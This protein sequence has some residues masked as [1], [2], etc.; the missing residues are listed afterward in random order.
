MVILTNCDKD[1]PKL[2]GDVTLT[3]YSSSTASIFVETEIL[4]DKSDT[5]PL[6]DLGRQQLINN[7]NAVYEVQG[8]NYGNYYARYTRLDQ[9]G[10]AVGVPRLKPFQARA[11][12]HTEVLIRL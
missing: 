6:I 11:N 3:F 4:I 12:E 5:E 9:E 7:N 8:L 2:T 1:E 10:N